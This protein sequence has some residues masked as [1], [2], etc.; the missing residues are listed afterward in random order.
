MILAKAATF[1]ALL[2]FTASAAPEIPSSNEDVFNGGRFLP[3]K[4]LL[5]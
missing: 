1:H 2:I 4:A 3:W 5:A